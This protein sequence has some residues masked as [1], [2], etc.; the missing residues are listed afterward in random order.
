MVRHRAKCVFVVCKVTGVSAVWHFHNR[1]ATFS[2]LRPASKRRNCHLASSGP[3]GPRSYIA[4][5]RAISMPK[6]PR[7]FDKTNVELNHVACMMRDYIIDRKPCY[8]G[9][10]LL[11][12]VNIKLECICSNMWIYNW[13]TVCCLN[14]FPKMDRCLIHRELWI[15]TCFHGVPGKDLL[16]SSKR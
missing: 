13:S 14:I 15:F 5:Y 7:L 11:R 4:C 3:S 6:R 8:R 12:Y 2:C 9:I 1:P 16:Y 10:Y